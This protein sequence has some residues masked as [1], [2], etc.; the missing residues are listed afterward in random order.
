MKKI[1]VAF[2]IIMIMLIMGCRNIPGEQQPSQVTQESSNPPAQPF[3]T[4]DE[5]P[6]GQDLTAEPTLHSEEIETVESP[7][8]STTTEPLQDEASPIEDTSPSDDGIADSS[9]AAGTNDAAVAIPAPALFPGSSWEYRTVYEGGLIPEKSNVLQELPGATVYHLVLDISDPTLAE[10]KMEAR[11]INQEEEAI[12]EL[13]LHM[14]PTHLGGDMKVADLL[15]NGQTAPFEIS[16]G[17]L[18]IDLEKPLDPGQAIVLSLSFTTFVPGEETTKYGVLAFKDNIL[19]LAHFYPMFAVYD[20]QGWHTE[21]TADHGDETFADMSFFLVQV[22]APE[23]QV[24]VTS[25]IEVNRESND[26]QQSLTY[27]AGPVRDFYL[28]ASDDFEVVQEQVGEVLLSSY[29][30]SGLLEGA[31][32]ALDVTADSLR[33]F[34]NRFGPYPYSELDIVTTPTDALGIEYP[35]IYANALRIYDLAGSAAGGISNAGLIESVSAHETA[36]QWF[37]N[38]V[39]NDQLNEPW[40]DEATAQYAT[41]LYFIDRYGEQNAQGFYNS[42]EGRWGR[43]EFAEIPIGLPADAYT[44]LEYSAIVYGRGPIFLNELAEL[45]GQETFDQFLRDF[46]DTY[47]WQI[48]YGE[49]FMKL[50]EKHC[51]CDL[52]DLF[53][54]EVFGN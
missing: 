47:S 17:M 6:V 42:L 33:S 24:L 53:A 25:G 36:H 23:D 12:D 52:S 32:I 16:N 38:V 35:G 20:D 13:F 41:W 43:I 8:P 31:Q 21:L 28:V 4:P 40:L 19:A 54:E 45:M 7:A 29:A 50:A 2:A 14:F 22:I 39:G 49:D 37:Y 1:T 3:E 48:A 9:S 15:I 34:S 5:Q 30:P 46:T 26:G 10:G 44:G 18:R 11:Y 51:N 27:A